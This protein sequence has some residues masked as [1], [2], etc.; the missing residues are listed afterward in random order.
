MYFEAAVTVKKT[1]ATVYATTLGIV[2]ELH[3]E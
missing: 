3:G 1:N 2:Q